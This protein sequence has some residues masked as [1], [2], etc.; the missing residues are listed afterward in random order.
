M[1]VDAH[2]GVLNAIIKQLFYRLCCIVN[3]LNHFVIVRNRRVALIHK[4]FSVSPASFATNF[5]SLQLNIFA[6][7]LEHKSQAASVV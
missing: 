7:C 2:N 3:G 4:N 5:T 6:L 1:T